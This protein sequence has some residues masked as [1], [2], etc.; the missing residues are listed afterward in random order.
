M[1][2]KGA[3][4]FLR[5]DTIVEVLLAI[6]IAAFAIAITYSTAQRSLNQAITA[7]EH[8]QALDIVQN[9]LTDLKLR[10]QKTGSNA[11][12]NSAF[13]F[14]KDHFC[15]DDSATTISPST[16][17]T[18]YLNDSSTAEG[19][20]LASGSSATASTPYHKACT[21]QRAGD[22]VTYYLDIHT[23]QLSG[24][25]QN[26][27]LYQVIVRWER[28]GGG[29]IN[30]ASIYY[31][32]NGGVAALGGGSSGSSTCADPAASNF[33]GPLPCTYPVGSS[34]PAQAAYSANTPLDPNGG[35]WRGIGNRT[36]VQ[37]LGITLP[38]NCTFSLNVITWDEGHP[39]NVAGFPAGQP[40]EQIWIEGFG[41]SITCSSSD[42]SAADKT[43]CTNV[44]FKT[45]L[46][47]DIPLNQ[48]SVLSTFSNLK[49]TGDIKNLLI[50]HITLYNP[51]DPA[52]QDSYNTSSV[53]YNLGNNNTANSVHGW[54]IGVNQMP[55]AATCHGYTGSN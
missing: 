31:R 21:R 6:G 4:G 54:C 20:P 52:G 16:P 40:Y 37:P 14:P 12:F 18:P 15:L 11:A 50:K 17:W 49:P 1:S 34:C 22:G 23:A 9:Q 10:Y 13:G 5:G 3:R 29:Q 25:T 43:N 39:D 41:S 46:T 26:P 33:G 32:L 47:S 51:S 8:N 44:L 24:Q 2:I 42:G 55:S 28:A 19:S 35:V 45:N 38:D 48:D 7:K 27:T 36:V 30:Q 53:Y